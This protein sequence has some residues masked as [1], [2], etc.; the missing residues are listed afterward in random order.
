MKGKSFMFLVKE[1]YNARVYG[2]F[3]DVEGEFTYNQW[4]CENV[5][6]IRKVLFDCLVTYFDTHKSDLA[7]GYTTDTEYE[8]LESRRC[9]MPMYKISFVEDKVI[10]FFKENNLDL[11]T[12]EG[13][14]LTYFDYEDLDWEADETY[15]ANKNL[16][17][18]IVNKIKESIINKACMS[19]P[20]KI[21][22][23]IND[24]EYYNTHLSKYFD[25]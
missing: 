13:K 19:N 10:N 12:Y 7:N 5:D 2:D 14:L 25:K 17:S 15:N 23:G 16:R 24:I 20:D 18:D 22:E 9:E 4:N 21:V 11:E 1:V 8:Y 3:G 6:E